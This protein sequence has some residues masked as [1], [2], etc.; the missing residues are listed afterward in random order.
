[1]PLV[2]NLLAQIKD[3][4]ESSTHKAVSRIGPLPL[5][6]RKIEVPIP[7]YL[8]VLELNEKMNR[9]RQ[10]VESLP[11]GNLTRQQQQETLDLLLKQISQKK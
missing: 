11:G 10:L 7:V 9:C 5:G 3:G 2:V 1:L 6:E 8:Q 4:D